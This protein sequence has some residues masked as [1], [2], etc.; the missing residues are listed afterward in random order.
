[1]KIAAANI[2]KILNA[3]DIEG[4][5]RLGAPTDEY[6]PEAQMISKAIAGTGEPELTQESLAALVRNVWLAMTGPLSEEQMA[7]RAGAFSSVAKEILARGGA[8]PK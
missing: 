1:M 3:A 6:A 2:Q 4:L 8:Q 5:L 7:K